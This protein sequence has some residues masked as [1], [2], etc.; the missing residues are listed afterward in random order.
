MPVRQNLNTYFLYGNAT[1]AS[2]ATANVFAGKLLVTFTQPRA[3]AIL[4]FRLSTAAYNDTTAPCGVFVVLGQSSPTWQLA[5]PA[6]TSAN[7]LVSHLY[8]YYG[9]GSRST[10]VTYS[11]QDGVRVLAGQPLS[12]YASATTS[13]AGSVTAALSFDTY[14]IEQ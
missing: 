9:S 8:G 1:F 13:A 3:F 14:F 6:A 11:A 2:L 7:L 5:T 10:P 4:G 12:I